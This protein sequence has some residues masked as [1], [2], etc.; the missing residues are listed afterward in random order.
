[1]YL[2]NRDFQIG[3]ARAADRLRRAERARVA[4]SALAGVDGR[5]HD[6]ASAKEG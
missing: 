6:G 2:M 5:T 1:M 3:R 4:A